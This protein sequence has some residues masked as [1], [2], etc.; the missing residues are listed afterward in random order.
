MKSPCECVH[1]RIFEAITCRTMC[2]WPASAASDRGRHPACPSMRSARTCVAHS[3][4][5]THEPRFLRAVLHHALRQPA[6]AC[7]SG[8]R[9]ASRW[10]TDPNG[11]TAF[12]WMFG[13]IAGAVLVAVGVIASLWHLGKPARVWR[14]FSQWRSS[15]MSR[16]GVFAIACFASC[17]PALPRH[18]GVGTADG[19][20]RLDRRTAGDRLRLRRCIPR[21]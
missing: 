8:W 7:G 18:V 16:E 4:G 10:A 11:S 17:G 1:V 3:E 12:G 20:T 14:A 15:W 19:P 2:N 13:L 21:R 5:I 9:C 6:S